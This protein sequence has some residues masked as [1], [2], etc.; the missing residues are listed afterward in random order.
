M[1]LSWMCKGKPRSCGG[2]KDGIYPMTVSEREEG[3]DDDV[4]RG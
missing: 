2:M 1:V 3:S 4:G